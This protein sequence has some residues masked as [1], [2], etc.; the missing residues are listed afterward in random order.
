MV[1]KQVITPQELWIP[2]SSP[3]FGERI[4]TPLSDSILPDST[5]VYFAGCLPSS[6]DSV[7]VF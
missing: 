3:Q 5:S 4:T 6:W 2:A 1:L 7:Q